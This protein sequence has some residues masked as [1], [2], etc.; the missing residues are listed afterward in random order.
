MYVNADSAKTYGADINMQIRLPFDL[1]LKGTYSYV[2]DDTKIKGRRSSYVRPHTAVM[3][4][5]YSRKFGNCRAT[6]GLNGRWMSGVDYWATSYVSKKRV[7]TKLEL[8]DYMIWKLNTSCIADVLVFMNF[9][10]RPKAP[11][12]R[13]QRHIDKD[14]VR[15]RFRRRPV[16]V[17]FEAEV[18]RDRSRRQVAIQRAEIFQRVA[19]RGEFEIDQDSSPVGKDQDVFRQ[20]VAMN[21]DARAIV[22]IWQI[23]KITK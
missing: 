20:Q 7:F 11:A 15:F 8:N 14:Q 21:R 9:E 1:T 17:C 2:Y 4:A 22:Q 10:P 16:Q 23:T 6:L 13:S 5:E 12:E 3:Q 19:E 18:W